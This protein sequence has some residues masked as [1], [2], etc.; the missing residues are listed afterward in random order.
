M[1]KSARCL[2][3]L[4]VSVSMLAGVVASPA[5]A[6]EKAKAEK[7]K[8][9][10]KVLLNNDMVQVIEVTYKP[11]D[12]SNKDY[13]KR[14]FRVV[15]ALTSGTLQRTYREGKIE[16]VVIKAGEVRV[17]EAGNQFSAKNVGASDLV[18]YGVI[19]KNLKE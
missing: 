1:K 3:S 8:P 12:E 11:G 19:L 15:R 2:T 9:T 13:K 6:V 14:P 16:Q 5:V 17:F 18:L 10:V 4:L 7:G